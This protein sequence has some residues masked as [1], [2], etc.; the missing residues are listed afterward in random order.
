M[1]AVK[2]GDLEKLGLLFERHHRVLF[3][4]FTKVTGSRTIA[5][6]LVQDV[7]FRIL[8]YRDTFRQ[9]SHFKAWM[10]HIA[11]NARL[12]YYRKHASERTTFG[13]EKD[14]LQTS[15][16]PP[17]QELELEEH[18][19]L[20]ECAL[21]KL[22]PEK[23][24]ILILSRYEEMKYEQIAELLDCEVGTVKVRF[25]R[26]MK[27]LRDIFLKLSSEK[28]PCTVKRSVNNLRIM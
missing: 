25:Y 23:R 1:I 9:D 2:N 11:R 3:D 7:F 27:E 20:L 16:V 19:L 26:A 21:L 8:K 28:Q 6:D 24:E 10:F 17:G 4:F 15:F 13:Q 22:A 5:E 12:D 14:E 18:T